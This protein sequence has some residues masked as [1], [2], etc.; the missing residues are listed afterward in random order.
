MILQGIRIRNRICLATS[1][2]TVSLQYNGKHSCMLR[3]LVK[4]DMVFYD[5]L[6]STYLR[7]Y[8]VHDKPENDSGICVCW[9]FPRTVSGIPLRGL[10]LRMECKSS[11]QRQSN[12]TC[13][14]RPCSKRTTTSHPPT[15]AGMF[16]RFAFVLRFNYIYSKRESWK[17]W[18]WESVVIW[19]ENVGPTEYDKEKFD[20]LLDY[21]FF[22]QHLFNWA[23]AF[24]Q[25]Q[26]HLFI[27]S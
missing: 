9:W 12:A 1:C 22:G 23:T 6:V 17:L 19:H 15:A 14:T 8:G 24:V 26:Q 10:V 18:G 25:A 11:L 21:H 2:T 7:G 20:A 27:T 3:C 13:P 4:Y 5:S 16:D